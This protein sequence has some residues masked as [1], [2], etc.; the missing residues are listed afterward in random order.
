M[1]L[2]AF[3]DAGWTGLEEALSCL[4]VPGWKLR[5]EP[6]RKRGL[7]ATKVHFDLDPAT[8][9]RHLDDMLRII[10]ASELPQTVRGAAEAI[11]LRLGTIEAAVHGVPVEEVHFHELGGLDTLLDIV[12]ACAGFGHF[13]F[14][15]VAVSPFAVG[16]GVVKTM[17][18]L[19]PV[20]TPATAALL[21]GWQIT[22]G[23]VDRELTTPTGAAILTHF[24]ASQGLPP[25][26]LQAVAHGAGTLELE[27]PNV[28][29]LLLGEEAAGQPTETVVVLE[30][31]VDDMSPGRLP[32]AME[33]L[34]AAGALDAFVTVVQGKK[35]R[36]AMLITAPGAPGSEQT[37][38]EVLFRHTSTIGV[39]YRS[40]QRR[41]LARHE[42]TVE[43]RFG[44]VR[45]KISG[46][47][48]W[49]KGKPEFDVGRRLAA[50]DSVAVDVVIQA[51]LRA[52]ERREGE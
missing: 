34:F 40:E 26:H 51:A 9:A 32:V 23:P 33:E 10:E 41:V 14:G 31:M 28:L 17:H 38:G 18:G 52:A 36:P 19:L 42:A 27:H 15:S 6:V 2:G 37:L 13:G 29:R 43:T 1:I 24:A 7:P 4:Q 5:I 3:V 47:G 22:A 25:M 8:S 20:P 50:E 11:F 46:E 21:H 45:V 35:G 12:G 16:G 39:R 44:P 30:T 49:R 48:S